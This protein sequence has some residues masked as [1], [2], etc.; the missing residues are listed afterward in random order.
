MQR[1]CLLDHDPLH[2]DRVC[3]ELL[4]GQLQALEVAGV[5]GVQWWAGVRPR[6]AAARWLAATFGDRRPSNTWVPGCLSTGT[7]AM[8]VLV[9]A[10]VFD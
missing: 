5:G 6:V 8:L 10:M 7:A 9:D 1:K 2:I 3:N 4:S